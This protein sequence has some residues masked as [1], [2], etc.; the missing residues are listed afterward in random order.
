MQVNTLNS[1]K[2]VA[3]MIKEMIKIIGNKLTLIEAEQ[4]YESSLIYHSPRAG[5]GLLVL[6]R[7]GSRYY[8]N[9]FLSL[10][11]YFSL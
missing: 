2:E 3:F 4:K 10:F 5:Q 1:F 6:E 7:F 8:T 11:L 9:L